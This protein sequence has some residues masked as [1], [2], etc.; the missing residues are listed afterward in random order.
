MMPTIG[1]AQLKL[2]EKLC[3]ASAVSGDI[4][5]PIP[6]ILFRAEALAPD[7]FPIGIE[8]RDKNVHVS[9]AV[10]RSTTEIDRAP[11]RADD[12]DVSIGIHGDRMTL[13][14]QATTEVLAPQMR[15]IGSEFRDEYLLPLARERTAAEVRRLYEVARDVDI[16]IVIDGNTEPLVELYAAEL[17]APQMTPVRGVPCDDDVP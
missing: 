2:L 16:S 13:F 6:K 11:E 15:S 9:C 1:N 4:P 7:V 12:K 3:N 5:T 8:S 14:H 17:F 10:D